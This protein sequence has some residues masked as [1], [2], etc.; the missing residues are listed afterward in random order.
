MIKHNIFRF[1]VYEFN[2][3]SI[4][5]TR[6][7]MITCCCICACC[8]RKACSCFHCLSCSASLLDRSLFESLSCS[9]QKSTQYNFQIII[10]KKIIIFKPF[11]IITIIILFIK[12]MFICWLLILESMKN[13]S[14]IWTTIKIVNYITFIK[15]FSLINKFYCKPHI[16]IIT[17]YRLYYHILL[18]INII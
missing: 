15:N 14:K 6:C 17:C 3:S 2:I 18:N 8:W 16:I 1:A 12:T 13:Y 7:S 10:I 4:P 11:L 9:C 5:C